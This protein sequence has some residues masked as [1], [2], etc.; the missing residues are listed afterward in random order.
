LT[1]NTALLVIDVQVGMYRESNPVA[2]GEE[3]LATL[4]SLI[5]RARN[6]GVPVIYVRHSGAKGGSLEEGTPGNEVHPGVAPLPGDI[7][8]RKKTPCSFNGTNLKAELDARGITDL[9]ITGIQSEMC[10]DTTCRSAFNMG[11]KNVLVEDGHSTFNTPDLS[12]EA[13]TRHHNRVLSH[14]FAKVRK[15]SEVTFQ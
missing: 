2:R 11:Y 6:A 12:A 13:I 9:V 7:V 10:V 1:Q 4:R 3:L 8:I 5:A 14:F 15:A